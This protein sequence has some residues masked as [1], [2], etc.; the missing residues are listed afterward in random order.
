MDDYLD[1]EFV[2]KLQDEIIED[3]RKHYAEEVIERWLNPRNFGTIENAQGYGK[4]TGGCG[5]VM[6]IWLRVLNDTIHE[7][8]FMTEGCGPTLACGSM[9]TEMVT[10]KSVQS[11]FK[12]DGQ[13]LK[14]R[15]GGLPQ[16][17]EHC[18]QLA[19]DT[20]RVAV[21]DYFAGKRTPWKKMYQTCR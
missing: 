18:A 8:R 10:G 14:D 9:V 19:A 1:D 6:E 2:K 17:H 4:Q 3:A 5:D 21:R 12:I 16:E 15:L 11:A 7:A 20:L 13:T